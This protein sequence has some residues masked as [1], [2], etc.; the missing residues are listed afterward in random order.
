[1]ERESTAG[2]R[3]PRR[4][5]IVSHTH[6]DREWYLTFQQF[7]VHL[8]ETVRAV[9]D[10]LDE[11]GPFRHFLL[12]GQT[13]VLDD[14]FEV[15][16]E[17]RLRVQHQVE[18]GRLSI[19]PWYVLSDEFLVSPESTARNLLIGHEVGSEFG[20][21]QDVGYM[22]DS[23]G[24]IAQMP[25][26]LKLASIGSF[27][28]TRG[29][30]DELDEL[31]SE[32]IW[33]APDGSSVMAVNQYG[34]YSNAAALG[35]AEFWHAHT[36]REL[37]PALA[38]RRVRDVFERA[39]RSS[40]V[41]ARLLMNGSDHLPPQRDLGTILTALRE[42]FPETEF[43]HTCLSTF[44]R[45]VSDEAES[46]P[47]FEGELLGGREH[48][49]LSGV[50]S[51]RMP[52]KQANDACETLLADVLEP[53][54]SYA[55]F[56]LGA[57]YPRGHLDHLWKLLLRNHAHDSICGCSIDEVHREME[58][59]FAAVT[60]A[61]ER[62][63]RDILVAQ[64]PTF[65][66]REDGDR[67]VVICVANTLPTR[68]D[69]VIDRTVVLV[70]P[71]PNI[72]DLA[73]LAED[74]EEVPFEIVDETYVERFWGIDYRTMTDGRRLRRLFESYLQNFGERMT[75]RRGDPGLTDCFLRV[76]FPAR[77]LPPVGHAIYRL[78]G[79]SQ[80][81]SA[82]VDL[83]SETDS[84][85][86]EEPREHA[87][88]TVSETCGDA[89]R[90]VTR[91][92]SGDVSV[93]GNV[94][95]NDRLAVTLN[96]DGSFDLLDKTSG[97]KHAGLNVL[98]DREDIGDEYDYSPCENTRSVTSRGVSG[99]VTIVDRG[100]FSAT[101]EAAFTLTLPEG[102]ASGRQRR[103]DN[104][105]DCPV[106]V[107]VR[108][109]AGSPLVDVELVVENRARDH[110][111]RALFP[112][113]I[114]SETLVSDGHFMINE[115]PIDR[116]DHP[117]W[118]QPPPDTAPQREFSLVENGDRGLAVLARGLPEVC[119]PRDKDGHVAIALTLLRC[120]GWLSRD[121]FPTRRHQNAGPTLQTP[122][123]Q[124]LGAH[125]FHYAVLPFEGGHIEADVKG[126]SRRWRTPLPAVQ[127]VWDGHEL[128]GRGLVA[129]SSNRTCV[130]TIKRC[131]TSNDLVVRLCNLTSDPTTDTL[132][133]GETVGGAWL[134]NLLEQPLE[135]LSPT[136]R[137]LDV[138]LGPHEIGT[139]KVR[140]REK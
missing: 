121:D 79:R 35:H 36:Q 44:L 68:R 123:A 42:A 57:E 116:G 51:A 92:D 129:S 126:I 28:Y 65:A 118:A 27:V 97:R 30:G 91:P 103:S 50:W 2:N 133:F 56:R 86:G 21:V 84:R 112:T 120:V 63:V 117:D 137:E 95:E 78:V 8:V 76:R 62:M 124:C 49:I 37:D 66:K 99:S 102:I 98:E 7:R 82:Q 52:L 132:R 17:E 73:L 128:G 22:P 93:D 34:G 131:Q 11:E 15:V 135:E 111:L 83:R 41:A 108:L 100:G 9:L 31:G 48:H 46:L 77:D 140:F 58:T 3:R 80:T 107:K 138:D 139:V 67:N 88:S 75:R 71:P 10:A 109:D 33:R 113:G 12:D 136:G 4:A 70:P 110:R 40:N 94:I 32:Y 125:R 89:P 87:G 61:A 60:E 24:H 38:V 43:S 105:V 39:E 23:F 72:D 25:Q 1:M 69:A 59:R 45:E 127:G 122:D 20:H 106:L 119:A 90:P 19:G 81:G 134:V 14:V 5:F 18:Q 101:L 16:P 115:R 26:I 96:V 29:N 64:A 104:V 130:T 55:H 47:E 114:A 6:W 13:V 85:P 54:A 53:L 74:G